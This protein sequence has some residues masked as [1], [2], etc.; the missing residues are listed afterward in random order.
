MLSMGNIYPGKNPVL[1]MVGAKKMLSLQA[2]QRIF[3]Y[4][5]H[6]RFLPIHE[7]FSLPKLRL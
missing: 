4:K 7:L 3:R 1:P 2:E 6:V 5:K